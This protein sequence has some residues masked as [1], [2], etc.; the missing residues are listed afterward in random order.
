MEEDAASG[1]EEEDQIDED[2][3]SSGEDLEEDQEENLEEDASDADA[4]EES[5]EAEEAQPEEAPV[6]E[7]APAEEA[8]PAAA[9]TAEVPPVPVKRV[10]EY[11]DK[12]ISVKATLER[13]DAVPDDA[14]LVV[15]PV[16]E[17]SVDYN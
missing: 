15:T 7:T 5:Q 16:T 3:E 4:S 11:S 2:G 12:N 13:A 10:Y 9:T 14:E 6:E 1:D 8:A 17:K